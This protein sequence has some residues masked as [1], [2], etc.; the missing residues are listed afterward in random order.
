M[1]PFYINIAAVST[2]IIADVAIRYSLLFLIPC[3]MYSHLNRVF[4][5][6]VNKENILVVLRNAVY[7]NTL[8]TDHLIIGN[9][10]LPDGYM[11]DGFPVPVVHLELLPL[12][13]EAW[14]KTQFVCFKPQPEEGFKNYPVTPA[15]GPRA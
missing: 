11:I 13:R 15:A 14:L 7:G 10:R 12:R 5:P 6:I 1:L 4:L 3:N 2:G 8:L 9:G